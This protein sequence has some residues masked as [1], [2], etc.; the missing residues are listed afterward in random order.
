M[1]GVKFDKPLIAMI[2]S[3]IGAIPAGIFSEIMIFFRFTTISAPKAT[4]M[5]FIREG[6]LALGVL[7]HIGYSA[8]LGL[9]LY[10]TP[11]FVGIDHYL[12]KAVFISMFAEAILFIVFGT[13]MRNEY[14]IQNAAGNYSQASAAAIAGLVRGYLIKRYLFEKPNS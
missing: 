12:I 10:Y 6:S 1:V 5:M 4:S 14:M 13:F 2:L 11:K 8:I 3:I 9:F 7:S